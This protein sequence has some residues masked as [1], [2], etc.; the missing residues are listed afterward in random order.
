[1]RVN[2]AGKFHNSRKIPIELDDF[3]IRVDDQDSVCSCFDCCVQQRNGVLQ[4]FFDLF[5]FGDVMANAD[6]AFRLPASS[7]ITSPQVNNVRIA[8]SARTM[9]SSFR[10]F[11]LV[12]SA[13]STAWLALLRSSMCT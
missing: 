13:C 10:N 6:H 7:R 5:A 2:S 9:R 1:M 4:F 12:A 8:L 11:P 3:A